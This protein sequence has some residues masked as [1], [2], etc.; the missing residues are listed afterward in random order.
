MESGSQDTAEEVAVLLSGRR[1]ALSGADVPTIVWIHVIDA[2]IK[3]SEPSLFES[4]KWHLAIWNNQQVSNVVREELLYTAILHDN[5]VMLRDFGNYIKSGDVVWSC[6]KWHHLSAH[7]AS[8]FSTVKMQDPLYSVYLPVMPYDWFEARFVPITPDVTDNI[9][10]EYKRRGTQHPARSAPEAIGNNSVDEKYMKHLLGVCTMTLILR[11][12]GSDVMWMFTADENSCLAVHAVF[13]VWTQE[14]DDGT[15]R[16]GIKNIERYS[17]IDP[18]RENAQRPELFKTA[19]SML[20]HAAV[21]RRLGCVR[22]QMPLTSQDLAQVVEGSAYSALNNYT[23]PV[24]PVAIT[25]CANYINFGYIHNQYDTQVGINVDSDRL[26]RHRRFVK[27]LHEILPQFLVQRNRFQ[28]VGAVPIPLVQNPLVP[29]GVAD[30]AFSAS[31]ISRP[32]G[33]VL[34]V[35]DSM[36]VDEAEPEPLNDFVMFCAAKRTDGLEKVFVQA[37]L[38]PDL[39]PAELYIEM[40][41]QL[42]GRGVAIVMSDVAKRV[43]EDILFDNTDVRWLIV[44]QERKRYTPMPPHL[45]DVFGQRSSAKMRHPSPDAVRLLE[46]LFPPLLLQRITAAMDAAKNQIAPVPSKGEQ[47][48]QRET[49]TLISTRTRSGKTRATPQRQEDTAQAVFTEETLERRVEVCLQPEYNIAFLRHTNRVT[50]ESVCTH[51][52]V[53]TRKMDTLRVVMARPTL[54]EPPANG[55]NAIDER[56]KHLPWQDHEILYGTKEEGTSIGARMVFQHQPGRDT[57]KLFMCHANVDMDDEVVPL[58]GYAV[59]DEDVDDGVASPAGFDIEGDL[60]A[61]RGIPEGATSAVL[62]SQSDVDVEPD[63]TPGDYFFVLGAISSGN[64][65]KNTDLCIDMQTV[66]KRYAANEYVQ[67][68]TALRAYIVAVCHASSETNLVMGRFIEMVTFIFRDLEQNEVYTDRRSVA[69][70]MPRL[71]S[72]KT[73]IPALFNLYLGFLLDFVGVM[74]QHRN[75]DQTKRGELAVYYWRKVNVLLNAQGDEAHLGVLLNALTRINSK[76]RSSAILAV[77]P[78]A[79][80]AL[81]ERVV[82]LS[83]AS[84]TDIYKP[85]VCKEEHV[86]YMLPCVEAWRR[87]SGEPLGAVE[88][89][90]PGYSTF[91]CQVVNNLSTVIPAK[92]ENNDNDYRVFRSARGFEFP[93][94]VQPAALSIFHLAK[95]LAE[96]RKQGP[97]FSMLPLLRS[98]AEMTRGFLENT[99]NWEVGMDQY[100]GAHADKRARLEKAAKVVVRVD[101]N[102]DM[103]WRLRIVVG[104]MLPWTYPIEFVPVNATPLGQIYARAQKSLSDPTQDAEVYIE[105]CNEAIRAIDAHRKDTN[106]METLARELVNITGR[107]ERLMEMTGT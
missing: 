33:T 20:E 75:H 15:W 24:G 46:E 23:V 38:E 88:P 65:D 3:S 63:T 104:E 9:L 83:T 96:D 43:N 106:T 21:Q 25:A 71:T 92:L 1:E 74:A 27:T 98:E 47:P 61:A 44:Q 69:D 94:M 102:A 84:D 7:A 51:V 12:H 34:S 80:P 79:N 107:Y 77:T 97:I 14:L 40:A 66:V 85:S 73:V 68:M 86:F 67:M 50:N 82:P 17:F 10:F 45:R 29:S 56:T 54:H 103:T 48:Q 35:S 100:R 78:E 81:A 49:R 5:E 39:S 8:F 91:L 60:R 87:I 16:S 99:A 18:R 11:V 22:L 30:I 76:N 26:Q 55:W 95:M 62:L 70:A 4:N 19:L 6:M 89:E 42:G 58:V 37:V 105:I 57:K 64:A 59:S 2:L 32:K 31:A 90:T 41:H 52:A 93:D 101:A 13:S 36:D 72:P 28:R 53:I